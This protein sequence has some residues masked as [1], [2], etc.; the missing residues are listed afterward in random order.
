M[1]EGFRHLSG[2][3][4]G[5]QQQRLLAL[6]ADITAA[7]PLYCPTMPKSG[8]PF[9]VR[10]TNCGALGW[11]SS[12]D[13][14]YRYQALHPVAGSPWPAM[15]DMLH[16][17]WRDLSDYPHAPQACLVN[18]YGPGARLG[19]HVDADE[20]ATQAPV[21]SVSLGD[22]AWFR[23]G[24]PKRRDPSERVLLKS[25]DVAILAGPARLAYHGI[26]RIV[27]GTSD[28]IDGPG[29]F[30]LTMRR[31]TLPGVVGDE[32]CPP[33]ADEDPGR[34]RNIT[35]NRANRES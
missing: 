28:L 25:G 26:D 6:I 21:I 29:R 30:N 19:L 3:L 15:P 1:I 12:K 17:I 27:A 24:G 5:E 8:K 16:D 35:N 34:R 33:A 23:V 11:V 9:S 7:A 10:M 22:D 18:W 2:Y 31:V 4:D 20:A 13:A 32:I 14:G